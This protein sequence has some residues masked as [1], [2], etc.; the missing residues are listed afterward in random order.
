[1]RSLEFQN[2]RQFWFETLRDFDHIAY[3]G[4]DFGEV[5]MAAEH[6]TS[7]DFESWYREWN[8]LADRVASEAERDVTAG[9]TVSAR[10]GFLRASTYYRSADF[11]LHGDPTDPRHNRAYD[12][13]VECFRQAAKFFPARVDT[14]EIPYQGTTLPG[15]FY[16]ASSE[17][18][19]R[20]TIIFHTGFDG[21]AEEMHFQGAA[22]VVERGY[23]ALMFDGPGQ[24]GPIHHQRLAFRPDWEN[25]VGPVIDFAMG[26][27]DVDPDRIGLWGLSMGGVLAPRAAAF[28]HRLGALVTVDGVYDFGLVVRRILGDPPDAE[29]RLR[30]E[31]DPELDAR[32]AHLMEDSTTVRWEMENGQYVFGV[33]TPRQ[34]GAALLDYNVGGGI[35]ER[36]T[37]PTLVCDGANDFLAGGQAK[38]L[39]EHLRCPKTFL[40]FTGETGAD[41]H[42]QLG[43]QRLAL[44]RICNWLDDT[45]A[46]PSTR[47][48][49]V[50]LEQSGDRAFASSPGAQ[51]D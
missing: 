10:D 50:R 3:G 33:E 21:A 51:H 19:R 17:G 6:I 5:A 27:P 46:S 9:H 1:M 39:Y 14:I 24:A 40:E 2:D 22:A 36:I 28:D 18:D 16:H 45:L 25:V 29:P 32:L 13:S 15:Y 34:V 20:P 26:L 31:N 11:F 43:G 7:G 38:L 37:C 30:A 44:A 49:T 47:P 12:R 48:S 4:A 23:N 35:A 42:C 41:E 8:G